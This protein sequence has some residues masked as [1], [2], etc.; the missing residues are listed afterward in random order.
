[1]IN[2][3]LQ[4]VKVVSFSD[5]LDKYGQKRQGETTERD[6]EM[7]VKIYTQTNVEDPKYVDIDVIGITKDKN[8]SDD[9]QIKIGDDYY[10]IKFI[11]PSGRYNQILMNKA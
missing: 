3:E 10:N 5:E 7:V 4:T 1:M 2:R 11:I 8:I 6:S 9:N